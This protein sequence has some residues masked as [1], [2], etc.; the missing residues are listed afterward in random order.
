MK[1][2]ADTTIY[3]DLL[4]KSNLKATPARLA[5]LHLFEKSPTPLSIGD[6]VKNLPKNKVDL[7]TV[8]RIINAL[9]EK[10]ILRQIEF[11]HG[12][13][14]YELQKTHHHHLICE[15]CGKV[16][17]IPNCNIDSL[18]RQALAQTDFAEVNEHSFELFGICNSC[19][20]KG[21]RI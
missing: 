14:H 19:A 13:A 18:K 1:H 4:H 2:T 7:V 20:K 8:Y 9:S 16:V 6:I 21:K 17:D 10:N 5:I 12:H 15:V 11:Q 3:K